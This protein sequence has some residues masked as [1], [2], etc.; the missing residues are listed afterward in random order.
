MGALKY[1][2][3]R[4]TVQIII[5]N[6]NKLRSKPKTARKIRKDVHPVEEVVKGA[7]FRKRKKHQTA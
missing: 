7:Y 2:R 6:R 3:N 1:I 4:K 5:E